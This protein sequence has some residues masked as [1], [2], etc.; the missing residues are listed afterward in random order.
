MNDRAVALTTGAGRGIGRAVV[1][2]LAR[3]G[4]D[5][6]AN[7]IVYDPADRSRGLLEVRDR[8]EG[9][10]A[11]C[12]PVPGDIASLP[13]QDRLIDAVLRTFGRIDLLVNNAGIAPERRTDLLETTPESYD[14]LM[15]VNARGAFFLSQRVAREMVRRR[16][17]GY[18][19]SLAII[20]IT[21]ISA[22]VSS[23]SRPEYCVSKA[24]LSQTAALF[25]DRLAPARIDVYEVRP[26]LIRTEM[27]EPVK[28]KYDALIAGGLVPQ[29]RW[30]EPEDV[31]RAVA[32]LA[33][34]ALGYSTGAVIEVSGGMNLRRL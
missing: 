27:T 33:G 19:G 10:G 32:A 31:A 30:G 20:F 3:H 29:G 9:L 5:I 7:D 11:R 6:A 13:D 18:A 26:G 1:L 4:F 2:E 25:A 12:L 34:G 24:A 23:P 21:S 14:R 28:E 8:I 15:A 16:D 17:A 22:V